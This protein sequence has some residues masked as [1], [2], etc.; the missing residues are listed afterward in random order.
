MV[1]EVQEEVKAWACIISSQVTEII[2]RDGSIITLYKIRT[3]EGGVE[4][5]DLS[6]LPSLKHNIDKR[7]K[8]DGFMPVFVDEALALIAAYSL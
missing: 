7:L 3:D 8:Q 4:K 1:E 5:S 6:D 2:V